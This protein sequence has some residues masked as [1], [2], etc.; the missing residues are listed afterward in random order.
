[1]ADSEGSEESKEGLWIVTQCEE[2]ETCLSTVY[3]RTPDI[4]ISEVKECLQWQR[5]Q[6]V[7]LDILFVFCDLSVKGYI[8]DLAD[9]L[10]HT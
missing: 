5:T 3:Q 10:M 1:M 2:I 8:S 6:S 9:I 7:F 4:A